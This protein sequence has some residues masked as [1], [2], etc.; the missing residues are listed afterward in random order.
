M[1]KNIDNILKSIS[2]HKRGLRD[3]QIMH[4]ERD[5]LLGI[6]M[7]VSIFVLSGGWSLALYLKNRNLTDVE[8]STP[9]TDNVVYR[10]SMV[11]EALGRLE[12]RNRELNSLLPGEAEAEAK[13]EVET[14]SSTDDIASTTEEVI[15]ETAVVE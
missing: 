7:A 1:N 10:E 8:S 15:D 9:Q 2:R 11:A 6:V 4:P 14:A 3:P 12:K 5:W 13:V